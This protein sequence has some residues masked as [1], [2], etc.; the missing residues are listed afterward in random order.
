MSQDREGAGV[1]VA[2]QER[3]CRALADALGWEV[4]Y[5]FTDNDVSASTGSARPGYTALMEAIERNQVQGVLAWHTD[6]LHRRPV[7]LEGYLSACEPRGIVTQTVEAGPLDLATPSGRAVARTLAA[8]AR[9][10]VEHKA[11]RSSAGMREAGMRGEWLGGKRAFGWDT[12]VKPPVL[13]QEEADAIRAAAVSLL[14]GKSLIAIADTWNAAG[15]RGVLGA[16]FTAT[17][18]RQ[19]LLRARNAGIATYKGEETGPSTFPAIIDEEMWRAVVALLK[20]PNRPGTGTDNRAKY[21]LSGLAKCGECGNV[22]GSSHVK[23]RDGENRVVYRC[24]TRGKGHVGKRQADADEVVNAVMVARLSMPDVLDS[25]V[26]PVTVDLAGLQS[27]AGTITARMDDLA[28]AY[29]DGAVTLTQMT[30]ATAKMRETLDGIQEQMRTATPLPAALESVVSADDAQ[31]AWN[32]TTLTDRRRIIDAL[33][34]VTILKTPPGKQRR[35]DPESIQI[36]W[37]TA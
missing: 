34:E 14:A 13:V 33:C 28:D 36:D 25:L 10:E 35:F 7:E 6:R 8:W 3:E 11:A 29:A 24:R 20:S 1:K 37:R 2:R 26:D 5:V 23:Y 22:V 30:A 27:Q 17:T 16:P 12:S 21:L 31:A 9:F 19:V 18:L 15:L 32:D 4:A